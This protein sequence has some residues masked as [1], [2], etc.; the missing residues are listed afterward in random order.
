MWCLRG[1]GV[2]EEQQHVFV[3][4][5]ICAQDCFELCL[6]LMV[7]IRAFALFRGEKWSE[8]PQLN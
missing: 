3:C 7:V 2:C 4:E 6:K 8:N 1:R 5:I